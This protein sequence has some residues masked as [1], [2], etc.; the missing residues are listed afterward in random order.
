MPQTKH[1]YPYLLI[2][3]AIYMEIKEQ[4][5]LHIVMLTGPSIRV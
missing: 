2:I 1:L 5:C 4:L 3:N